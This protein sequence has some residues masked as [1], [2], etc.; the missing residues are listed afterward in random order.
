MLVFFFFF[1]SR[2]RH[3]RCGRDWSSDVCSSDLTTP[4]AG[5]EALIAPVVVRRDLLHRSNSVNDE[6]PRP[7]ALAEVLTVA[8][9]SVSRKPCRTN[10][11]AIPLTNVSLNSGRH[12]VKFQLL[13]PIGGVRARPFSSASAGTGLLTTYTV[14]AVRLAATSAVAPRRARSLRGGRIERSP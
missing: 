14:E 2:R 9:A 4:C 10:A 6:P 7:I 11:S 13:K 8:V 3:T 1:S 5:T 12:C